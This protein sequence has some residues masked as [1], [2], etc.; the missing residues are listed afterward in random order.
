MKAML[1]RDQFIKISKV[2]QI[3]KFSSF[4]KTFHVQLSYQNWKFCRKIAVSLDNLLLL[5]VYFWVFWLDDRTSFLISKPIKISIL[6][7]W[8]PFVT[9]APTFDPALDILYQIME[10]S[11]YEWG[12]DVISDKL[13]IC[14]LPPHLSRLISRVHDKRCV[15]FQ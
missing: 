13:K 11:S 9:S 10:L 6:F 12:E 8:N 4:L 3:M 7:N 2:R 14:Q 5:D 1:D 15:S